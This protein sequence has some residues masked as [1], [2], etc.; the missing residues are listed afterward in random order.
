M[1]FSDKRERTNPLPFILLQK[2]LI[3]LVGGYFL[4]VELLLVDG[5]PRIDNVG[6]DEG[7]EDADHSHYA[8]CE[9]AAATVD[10]GERA[11]EVGVGWIVGGVVESCS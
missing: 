6:D 8:E 7:N 5:I 1:Q 10:N 9:L 2:K 3:C 11:L 4:L